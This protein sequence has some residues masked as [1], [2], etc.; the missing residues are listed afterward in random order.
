LLTASW[1]AVVYRDGT[2]WPGLALVP[3]MAM[4]MLCAATVRMLLGRSMGGL[5]MVFGVA[6]MLLGLMLGGAMVLSVVLGTGDG[7]APVSPGPV[8]LA[9]SLAVG[10]VGCLVG[11]VALGHYVTR[12]QG[13]LEDDEDFGGTGAGESEENIDYST[14]PEELVCL[15]TNQMV[16]RDRD[17]YLVCHNRLN[18]TSV[19]HA[20]YLLD[21]VHLL[22]GRCRRCYQSLRERD[23]RGMRPG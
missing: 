3:P 15:L 17:R 22:D 13:D 9:L 7:A 10:A 8:Q 21:Y 19:C 5:L 18:V 11:S 1:G 2:Y 14:E 4:G 20:V 16:N 12:D 6:V 23:L